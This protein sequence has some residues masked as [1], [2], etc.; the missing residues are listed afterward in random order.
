MDLQENKKILIIGGGFGGIRAALDLAKENLSGTKIILVSDKPHFEYHPA[1]YRIVTGKSPLEVCIPIR[2]V[3]EGT[4]VELVIDRITAI[5]P[6]KKSAIGASGSHYMADTIILALGSETA[7]FNVPGLQEFS[8]G[9]KSITEALRLKQHIHQLFE[10]CKISD[11]DTH[12]DLCRMHFVVVGAGASG[13]EFAGELAS[14]TK[15]L[16]GIHN[17]SESLITIDLIDGAATILPMFP[18]KFSERITRRLRALGVNIFTNRSIIQEKKEEVLVQG[19]NIKTDTVIWTAGIKPN[20]LYQKIPGLMFDQKGKV[21][22]DEYLHAKGFDNL[23]VIGDGAATPYSGTAQTAIHDGK[24]VAK[25]ILRYVQKLSLY[26]YKPKK[27]YY[28]LP[29]GPGWA[30]ATIGPF[31][32]YGF[33]GWFLRRSADF[34]YFLSILS[35]KKAIAAFRSGKTICESCAICIPPEDTTHST[36]IGA[37]KRGI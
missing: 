1:L 22:V 9:F 31:L 28:M 25:N 17:I 19:I 32:V 2:E 7:Y 30:A 29:V 11:T 23:F 8:F 26:K 24:T 34:L 10:T 37:I 13:V 27:P 16:A 36:K 12:E 20:S 18:Q 21:V 3:L 6:I 15:K 5:D 33:G 35:F 14:Y 4:S